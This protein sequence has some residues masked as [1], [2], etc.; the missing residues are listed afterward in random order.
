METICPTAETDTQLRDARRWRAMAW[1]GTNK[2][3]TDPKIVAIGESLPDPDQFD[4][5][6]DEV[7]SLERAIDATVAHLVAHGVNLDTAL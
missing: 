1:C 5:P 7:G 6:I 4:D 2:D 3:S